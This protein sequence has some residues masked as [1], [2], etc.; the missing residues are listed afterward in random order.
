MGGRA[1]VSILLLDL[2]HIELELKQDDCDVELIL[3]YYN[4]ST[5]MGN[6]IIYIEAVS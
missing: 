1:A 2:L 3:C 5:H 6:E 4:T